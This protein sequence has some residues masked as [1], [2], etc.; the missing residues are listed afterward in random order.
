M[1]T[2]TTNVSTPLATSTSIPT[3]TTTSTITNTG[4]PILSEATNVSSISQRHMNSVGYPA[5]AMQQQSI[6]HHQQ[7]QMQQHQQ[8]PL[9]QTLPTTP[10]TTN[11]TTAIAPLRALTREEEIDRLALGVSVQD[12]LTLQMQQQQIQSRQIQVIV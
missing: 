5:G 2:T 3:T 11:T 8:P 7:M 12:F 10:C 9:V 6:H 1:T 4:T